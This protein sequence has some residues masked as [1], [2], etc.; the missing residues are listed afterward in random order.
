IK[1]NI[2]QLHFKEFGSCVYVLKINSKTILID[3]SSASAKEELL[4]DLETL[5]IT[6]EKVEVVILTHNHY[7]HIE[8][9]NL[10]KNAK[11]YRAEELNE[12]SIIKE[13]SE[14]KIIETPGHTP[15]SKC[16]LYQDIL[17]SGDTIFHQGGVGRTDLPGGNQEK[18]NQSLKK[19]KKINF[20]ILCP[21][22]I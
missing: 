5:K 7:D 22:H 15:E 20:K 2:S 3:T 16:F 17:F 18:L 21:G 14:M 19:L 4:N 11:I 8:N 13:L 6:P 12:N 1:Q 10:F 9:L